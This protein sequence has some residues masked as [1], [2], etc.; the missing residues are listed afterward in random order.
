VVVVVVGVI[1]S[2][3]SVSEPVRWPVVV[4]WPG[5]RGRAR[6]RCCRPVGWPV[7]LAGWLCVG[8]ASSVAPRRVGGRLRVGVGGW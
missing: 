7:V 1:V 8:S 2:P 6:V 5:G 4:G 3:S